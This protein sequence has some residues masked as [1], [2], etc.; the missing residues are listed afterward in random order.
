[1]RRVFLMLKR[2]ILYSWPSSVCKTFQD[3]KSLTLLLNA[4]LQ[5]LKS[6]WLL[7]TTL[8]QPEPL[9]KML[10][11]LRDKKMSWLCKGPNSSSLL[12]ELS[13]KSA[14]LQFVI[15]PEPLNKPNKNKKNSE[16]IQL[17]TERNSIKLKTIYWF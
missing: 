17:P 4:T 7:V 5:A 3:Q 16:L 15:A 14:E 2:E 11:L 8:L 13:V 6:E 10:V 12:E 9:Q 1:M